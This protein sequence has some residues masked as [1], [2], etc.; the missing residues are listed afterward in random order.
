MGAGG[1]LARPSPLALALTGVCVGQRACRKKQIA[2]QSVCVRVALIYCMRMLNALTQAQRLPGAPSAAGRE[3]AEGGVG[4]RGASR[5]GDGRL[6]T[7]TQASCQ[8][9]RSWRLSPRHPVAA[10]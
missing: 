7:G 9:H 8:L 4:R 3:D 6:G 10:R 1:T 5:A 2:L